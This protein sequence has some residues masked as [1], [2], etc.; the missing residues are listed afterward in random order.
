MRFSLFLLHSESTFFVQVLDLVCILLP[1]AVRCA[2]IF[3]DTFFSAT[4]AV[5]SPPG[6]AKEVKYFT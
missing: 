6:T 3:K 2:T 1:F 5:G 4:V